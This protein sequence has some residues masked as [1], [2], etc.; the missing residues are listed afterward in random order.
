MLRGFRACPLQ[1]AKATGSLTLQKVLDM[2][3]AGVDVDGLV[4][5]ELRLQMYTK[6][7]TSLAG[8]TPFLCTR[9]ALT[10]SPAAV[11]SPGRVLRH[12]F[13]IRAWL[14]ACARIPHRQDYDPR[15]VSSFAWVLRRWQRCSAMAQATLTRR[16]C[17]TI[18]PRRSACLRSA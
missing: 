13:S 12:C 6:E 5:E 16:G 17:C 11:T 10:P 9:Q 3:E 1:A 4:S 8:K 14:A 18:C 15:P 2:K 7:V